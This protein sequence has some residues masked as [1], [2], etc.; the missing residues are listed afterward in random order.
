L[1]GLIILSNTWL[2]YSYYSSYLYVGTNDGRVVRIQTNDDDFSNSIFDA[3]QVTNQRL[4]TLEVDSL[5][6]SLYVTT[7]GASRFEPA[8]VFKIDLTSWSVV[9]NIT[10]ETF[11][12]SVSTSAIVDSLAGTV[13]LIVTPFFNQLK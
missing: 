4:S 2:T 3:L 7:A 5:R 11:D 8:V 6:G 10:L 12:F 13:F 1:L 9:E